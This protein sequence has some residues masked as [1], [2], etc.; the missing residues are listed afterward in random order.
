MCIIL[1]KN[2]RIFGR[3]LKENK[4]YNILI[5]GSLHADPIIPESPIQVM[6][7]ELIDTPIDREA[8]REKVKKVFD[9]KGYEI[10]NTKIDDFTNV[11]MK[12]CEVAK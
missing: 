10:P 3:A 1:P 9:T 2:R 8:I 4:I 11:I 5:T 12:A 7:R 6:E